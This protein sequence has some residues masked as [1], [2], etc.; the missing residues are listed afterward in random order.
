MANRHVFVL[1]A[2]IDDILDLY[3][4]HPAPVMSA[5]PAPGGGLSWPLIARSGRP[6]TLSRRRSLHA[7]QGLEEVLAT[8]R[9]H[10]ITREPACECKQGVVLEG[11][12]QDDRRGRIQ[13][14]QCAS[15]LQPAH[16]GNLDI[17]QHQV[18]SLHFAD[19]D[20]LQTV[21]RLAGQGVPPVGVGQQPPKPFACLC[22]IVDDQDVHNLFHGSGLDQVDNGASSVE[23]EVLQDAPLEPGDARLQADLPPPR[24]FDLKIAH[25]HFTQDCADADI[26]CPVSGVYAVPS[27][28]ARSMHH[29]A[30]V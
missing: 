25:H 6:A 1:G 14:G 28:R 8:H 21:A 10:Q 11:R 3:G 29:N 17:E 7:H 26:P 18:D 24:M 9:L 2:Q 30:S 15:G 13:G 23:Q 22:F 5:D 12:H 27:P 19:L 20:R 16:S 4:T